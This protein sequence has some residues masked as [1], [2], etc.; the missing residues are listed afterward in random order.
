MAPTVIFAVIILAFLA[1]GIVLL[2]RYLSGPAEPRLAAA[3]TSSLS[4]ALANANAQSTV[5]SSSAVAPAA[6]F[7][8][9]LKASNERVWVGYT[10]DGTRSEKILDP[11]QAVHLDVKDTLRLSYAKVKSQNLDLAINGKHINVLAGGPKGN[12]DLDINKN[13]L[14]QILQSG[15]LGTAPTPKP[16]VVAATPRPTPKPII[17][18]TPL[19]RATIPPPIANVGKRPP[20]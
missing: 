9:D 14:A 6:S 8:V 20:Q 19:P 13:N 12:F 1:G 4:N 11:E 17:S 5:T 3:N 18:P 15:E 2:V 10:L 7:A 16:T